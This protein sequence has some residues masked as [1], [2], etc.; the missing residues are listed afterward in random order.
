MRKK[1]EDIY[2]TTAFKPLTFKKKVNKVILKPLLFIIISILLICSIGYFGVYPLYMK[3]FYRNPKNIFIN[4]TDN[5]YEYIRSFINDKSSEYYNEKITI[6]ID[7]DFGLF[8]K[9]SGEDYVLEYG[10]NDL[11]SDLVIS[12]KETSF[13]Y[14]ERENSYYKYTSNKMNKLYSVSEEDNVIK[15]I[16]E[17]FDNDL[18]SDMDELIANFKKLLTDDR[19]AYEDETIVINGKDL[20]V[21]RNS[22]TL[23]G[24]DLETLFNKEFKD[25]KVI[26]NIYSIGSDIKGFDI[27]YNGFRVLYYYH[28]NDSYEM[29]FNLNNIKEGL[30]YKFVIYSTDSKNFIVKMN[31]VEVGNIVLNEFGD[32]NYNLDLNIRVLSLN[33]KGSLIIN[34]TDTNKDIELKTNINDNHLNI[35]VNDNVQNSYELI[36]FDEEKAL[37][38]NKDEY[39]SIIDDLLK[40]YELIDISSAFDDYLEEVEKEEKPEEDKD[41][42][43]KSSEEE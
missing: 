30:N 8:K 13:S 1:N 33:V 42:E 34:L 41:D 22:L 35:K 6:S 27:E 29:Y 40:K 12:N 18:S 9:I 2:L 21:V 20:K 25:T 5:T 3:Y 43:D 37:K 23:N 7:S 26:I 38:F 24:E 36:E 28:D 15:G 19:L 17:Y 16:R 14:F 31:D 11:N 4:V 10:F 32:N 39:N